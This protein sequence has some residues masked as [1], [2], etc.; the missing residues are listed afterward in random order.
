MLTRHHAEDR[1]TSSSHAESSVK[2]LL[3]IS[4]S[5]LASDPRVNR[6]IRLLG[7]D[8]RVTAAGYADPGV[9]NVEFVEI[10]RRARS[11]TGKAFAL[12]MLK[13]GQFERF[14]WTS[15]AVVAARERLVGRDFDLI[16]ANDIETLPLALSLTSRCGVVLDAH[17][18]A[19]RELEDSWQWRFLFQSYVTYLC[20]RYLPHVAGV[21]TVCESIAKEYE[22]NFGVSPGVVY[23]A[24]YR[25]DLT[26]TLPVGEAVRL[27][28]HGAAS[29]SR[30]IETMMAT[31]AK[32]DARFTLDLYLV[33]TDPA[34]LLRLERM[35]KADERIR[36]RMPVPMTELPRVLNR[37]DIGVYILEPNS[38]NNRY[39]LPNKFFEFIQGRIAVAVGPSPEMARLVRRYDLGVVADDFS[40]EAMTHALSRLTREQVIHYKE[41][42]DAAAND[43]CYERASAEL[44]RIVKKAAGIEA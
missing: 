16:L 17:E 15:T 29:P 23:N 2:H 20:E 42:A 5:N 37:Y 35:A 24:P 3:V 41:R 6:Q 33:P 12:A 26:P 22:R 27:V 21:A 4:F 13:T 30:R 36:I 44:L 39:S 7:Q 1:P 10:R 31:V 28:H 9:P 19:P 14:Y 32:L 18:Y 8:F 11:V 34:Y 40:S 38:L 25:A 43:L